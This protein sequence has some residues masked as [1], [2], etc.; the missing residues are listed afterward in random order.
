MPG[1]AMGAGE[2][3]KQTTRPLSFQKLPWMRVRKQG[4]LNGGG[5]DFQY[6]LETF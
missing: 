1:T 4:A 5:G 2:K 3:G 6:L